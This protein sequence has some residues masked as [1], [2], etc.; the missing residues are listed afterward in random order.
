MCSVAIGAPW[1][2]VPRQD[3]F[4]GRIVFAT[5]KFSGDRGEVTILLKT[6]HAV[7][8]RRQLMVVLDG[9]RCRRARRCVRLVGTL[10]GSLIAQP[11][12]PDTGSPFV[13][14]AN[15]WIPTLGNVTATGSVR[16][17][18]FIRYAYEPLHLTLTAPRGRIV[19]DAKSGKVPG[20]TSP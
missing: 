10:T 11:H 9:R 6:G 1:L 13:I 5:G 20:F 4:V 19:L 17:T 16:G 7:A 3:S 15:G 2:R 8:G 14:A 12:I 18:G